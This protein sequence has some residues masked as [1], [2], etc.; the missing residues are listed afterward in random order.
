MC[1]MALFVTRVKAIKVSEAFSIL[2]Y[3][4]RKK[5]RVAIKEPS[6]FCKREKE[7]IRLY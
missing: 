5:G 3:K 2:I 4:S 6:A 1:Y 7:C